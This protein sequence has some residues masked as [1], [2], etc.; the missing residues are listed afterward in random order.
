MVDIHEH[1]SA[2][3]SCN[4]FYAQQ[5]FVAHNVEWAA[6]TLMS[7][8]LEFLF[9]HRAALNFKVLIVVNKL[10]WFSL[11]INEKTQS[12]HR[13][14]G[15]NCLERSFNAIKIHTVA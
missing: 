15:E 8:A 7:I 11:F 12:Q 2:S 6:E 3:F 10:L 13:A 14:F 9:G 5:W 1:I 4:E